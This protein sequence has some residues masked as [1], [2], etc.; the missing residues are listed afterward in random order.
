M[1]VLEQLRKGTECDC[2]GVFNC[3]DTF[4]NLNR[5]LKNSKTKKKLDHG[6]RSKNKDRLE[7]KSKSCDDKIRKCK[8]RR[9]K[10][11]KENRS[12][13]R[14]NSRRRPKKRKKTHLYF[15]A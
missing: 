3:T 2:K 15:V 11:P 1:S 7:S 13:N 4:D 5:E 12:R 9:H 6:K 14:R 8:R 10:K